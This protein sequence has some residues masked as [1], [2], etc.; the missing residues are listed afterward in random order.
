MRLRFREG[1][2]VIAACETSG[3]SRQGWHKAIKRTVMRAE[4]ETEKRVHP[5][6]YALM[7]QTST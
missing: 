1:L 2:T 7:F 6:G 5:I 3:M 4:L